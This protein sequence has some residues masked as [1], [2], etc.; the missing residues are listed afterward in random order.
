MV[1]IVNLIFTMKAADHVYDQFNSY[2]IGVLMFCFF[3]FALIE[4]ELLVIAH[5]DKVKQ[6]SQVKEY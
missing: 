3:V 5:E 6:K 4:N 1:N 2:F